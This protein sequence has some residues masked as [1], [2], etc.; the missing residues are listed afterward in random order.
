MLVTMIDVDNVTKRFCSPPLS[1]RVAA[2][3]SFHIIIVTL[4]MSLLTILSI[5]YGIS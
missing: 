3:V 5:D 2:A 4:V 1:I